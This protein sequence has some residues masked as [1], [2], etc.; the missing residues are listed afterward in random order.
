MKRMLCTQNHVVYHGRAGG[1]R[2]AGWWEW[3]ALSSVP[4]TVGVAT[5]CWCFGHGTVLWWRVENGRTKF[6]F[7]IFVLQ[8]YS[9]Y[10][11][12]IL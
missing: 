4:S 12:I 2:C 9:Y 5:F 7:L 1:T 6:V 3:A 8:K 10:E 11:K